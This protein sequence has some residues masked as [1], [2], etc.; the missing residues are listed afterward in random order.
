MAGLYL[1]RRKEKE[2]CS[3]RNYLFLL[4]SFFSIVFFSCSA[5]GIIINKG[6]GG[7]NTKDLLERIDED[8]L[9]EDPQIAIIMIGTNDMINSKK[10]LSY[11]D[12]TRNYQ[13]IIDKFQSKGIKLVLM[14]PP[15]VDTAYLFMR[16][17]RNIYDELPNVKIDS[18]VHI[19]RKLAADNKTY[20]IDINEI[21][22]KNG[23][24]NSDS[25]SLLINFLN[26]GKRDGVHPTKKGYQL[27]A[28]SIFN[29]LKQEHL[30]KG[31][32]KIL[33]FG[34]SITYGAFMKGEGTAE[35]DTYPALLNHL[36]RGRR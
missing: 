25:D 6:I 35:G 12:F 19:T 1:K 21:F 14:T 9:S 11:R 28:N 4:L 27:V 8:A 22:K 30:L 29:L 10:F 32:V 16:H 2:I 17:S 33:C 34:D 31:K 5:K 36:I 20:F 26:S 3:M 23:S 18:I 15:P 13:N 7:N 24:P